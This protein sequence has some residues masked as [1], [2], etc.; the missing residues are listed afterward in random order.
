MVTELV[1]DFGEEAEK[2]TLWNALR[3]LHRG[4]Q[5]GDEGPCETHRSSWL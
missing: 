4:L 5:R 2:Q 1:I 3:R